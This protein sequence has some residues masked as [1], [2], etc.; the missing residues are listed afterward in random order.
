MDIKHFFEVNDAAKQTWL[1]CAVKFQHT[2]GSKQLGRLMKIQT[3]CMDLG[4]ANKY[5]TT[6]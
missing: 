3:L 6:A 4:K 2:S 1:K 5:I